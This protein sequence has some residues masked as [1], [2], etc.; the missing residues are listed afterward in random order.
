M[1]ISRL[2]LVQILL[3]CRADPSLQN[4]RGDTPLVD[5]LER[6]GVESRQELELEV[7]RLLATGDAVRR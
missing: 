6:E 1:F 3:E 5:F 2:S 7:V 4:A